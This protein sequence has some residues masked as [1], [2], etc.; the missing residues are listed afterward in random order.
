M[1]SK[2]IIIGILLSILFV[3][4]SEAHQDEFP[5][6]TGPYLG[7]KPPGMTPESFAPGIITTDASEGC[8]G[9]GKNMEYFIFQRWIDGKSKLYIMN[10]NN[11]EW[12]APILISFVD[13]YQVGDFTIAPD[14]N[15]MVFASKIVIQEI[16]SEGEGANIWI[17]KRTETGWTKPEHFGLGIN[18]KYH[19]SYPCLAANDNLYFFSRRPGG[20]GDSDLYLSEFIDGK[21]QAPVNL[22]PNLNTAHHEWDTYIA[23]DESYMIYCSMKPDSIG[24][25]DLY[26]TFKTNDGLWSKPVHMGNE[27]NTDKSENRPYVS[28]DGK[29]FFYTSNKR[30]NRDIYWVSAKIIEDLK[31]RELRKGENL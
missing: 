13:K 22:G 2:P 12:N 6:L 11:G 25:D 8:S 21:Y 15:T 23:P 26:V 14:G 20:Y 7:L 1:R 19:D 16:G 3:F 10:Q 4:I 24:S 30:G 17:V 27:I 31:P 5:V 28:P 9:W 29:Y 18:T